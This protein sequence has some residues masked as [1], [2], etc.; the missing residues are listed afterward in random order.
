MTP[1]A[2]ARGAR[3]DDLVGVASEWAARTAG[4]KATRSEK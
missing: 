1:P 3:P 4:E 2:T